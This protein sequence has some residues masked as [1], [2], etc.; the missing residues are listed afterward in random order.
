[1][2]KVDINQ[3]HEELLTELF[4]TTDITTF[5]IIESKM[6]VKSVHRSAYTKA[7][8]KVQKKY[9]LRQGHPDFLAWVFTC[10][11]RSPMIIEDGEDRRVEGAG[12]NEPN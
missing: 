12:E 10:V 5:D 9:G 11:G 4:G 2:G 7:M 3:A 1:M 8:E 6:K